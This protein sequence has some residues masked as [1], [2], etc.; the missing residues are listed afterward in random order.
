MPNTQFLVS[1]TLRAWGSGF[2][3]GNEKHKF[4]TENF[5]RSILENPGLMTRLKMKIM[6]FE[7]FFLKLRFLL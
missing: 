1:G 6:V 7:T 2:F 3:D 4:M 5:S